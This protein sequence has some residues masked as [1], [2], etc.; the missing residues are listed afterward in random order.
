MAISACSFP[1]PADVAECRTAS[2]CTSPAAPF[3]VAGSCVA[4]CQANDD[5]Q[6]IAAT[7]FCQTTSGQCVAC[8]D[9]S[10][11]SAD[12]PACDA[13]AGVCRGCAR[14]EECTGGICVEADG[15]CVADA[16][17]IFV[18]GFGVNAGPCTKDAP[19]SLP[20][21]VSQA[22]ANRSH[23]KI[24]NGTVQLSATLTLTPN[25]YIEGTDTV[26]TGPPGMFSIAQ[27]VTVTAT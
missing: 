8:L 20:F 1:K 10:V 22:T 19:C 21:G 6:G 7:P 11:C 12:K 5:C 23:I 4:A 26:V 27:F 16:D 18:A 2:D 14:D 24:L 9:A 3:C 25:L 15:T 17:V 13:T